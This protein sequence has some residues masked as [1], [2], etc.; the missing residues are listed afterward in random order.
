MGWGFEVGEVLR[1][2]GLVGWRRNVEVL[3]TADGSGF[4]PY[5]AELGR[6]MPGPAEMSLSQEEPNFQGVVRDGRI[7]AG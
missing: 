5:C 6:V 4:S 7:R 1:L 2:G 3:E